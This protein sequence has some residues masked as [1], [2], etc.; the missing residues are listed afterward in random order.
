M[1]NDP[2]GL[3]KG[4]QHARRLSSVQWSGQGP[5]FL[6]NKSLALLIHVGNFQ[7]EQLLA[8]L[9]YVSWWFLVSLLEMTNMS[10]RKLVQLLLQRQE[11]HRAVRNAKPSGLT[12]E[13][14]VWRTYFSQ[15]VLWGSSMWSLGRRSAQQWKTLCL[16]PSLIVDSAPLLTTLTKY[17]SSLLVKQCQVLIPC[18]TIP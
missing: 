12:V 17:G 2:Y 8:G 15:S 1:L 9:G 11:L 5:S 18:V 13:S 6:N 10:F 4:H 3:P 7:R 16:L 14:K